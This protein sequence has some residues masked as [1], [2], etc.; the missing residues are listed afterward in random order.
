MVKYITS[1]V[2]ISK[3]LDN[4]KTITYKLKVIDSFRCMSASLSSLVD[5]LSEIY[6]KE[7]K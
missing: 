2:P 3:E 5:N 7:C 6:K 4:S 1:S